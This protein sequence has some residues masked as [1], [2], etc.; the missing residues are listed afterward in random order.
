MRKALVLKELEGIK[1]RADKLKSSGLSKLEEKDVADVKAVNPA[2][3]PANL[4]ANPANLAAP[5]AED[6]S[7]VN[8]AVPDAEDADAQDAAQDALA[9]SPADP[10]VV[11]LDAAPADAA[12]DVKFNITKTSFILFIKYFINKIYNDLF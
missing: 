7:P 5:D 12:A 4:A 3:S 6:A 11:L 10:A 9:E 2:A 8:P 1:A